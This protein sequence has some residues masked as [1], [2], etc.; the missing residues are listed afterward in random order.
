MGAYVAPA[1]IDEYLS[2][3]AG[4]FPNGVEPDTVW[5][6]NF[7][8]IRARHTSTVVLVCFTCPAITFVEVGRSVQYFS[9]IGGSDYFWT[10]PFLLHDVVR[11]PVKRCTTISDFGL[12]PPSVSTAA[13]WGGYG[14]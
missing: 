4:L 3:F 5:Y 11:H 13:R 8:I 1:T 10:P 6:G 12:R 7:D 9:P 2:K 14:F